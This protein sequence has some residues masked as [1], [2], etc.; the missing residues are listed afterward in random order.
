MLLGNKVSGSRAGS[1][2]PSPTATSISWTSF[3]Q[4]TLYSLQFRSQTYL[5]ASVHHICPLKALEM[6]PCRER[7]SCFLRDPGMTSCS[8]PIRSWGLDTRI[9]SCVWKGLTSNTVSPSR[10]PTTPLPSRVTHLPELG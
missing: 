1:A 10:L 6:A 5:E 9:K 4:S 8:A 7:S 3:Q 2:H